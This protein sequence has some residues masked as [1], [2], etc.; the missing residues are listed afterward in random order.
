MAAAL[1]LTARVADSASEIGTDQPP[2]VALVAAP[3]A[4]WRRVRNPPPSLPP[5]PSQLPCAAPV[6]FF[7]S[8]ARFPRCR[9]LLSF[10]CGNRPRCE[11]P[12]DPLAKTSS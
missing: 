12:V 10:G 4:G 11:F 6:L 2:E 7:V 1:A 3:W 9:V 5:P 8:L